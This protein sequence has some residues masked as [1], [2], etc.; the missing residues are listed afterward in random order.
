[1]VAK[2]KAKKAEQRRELDRLKDEAGEGSTETILPAYAATVARLQRLKLP[3]AVEVK[4]L[5]NAAKERDAQLFN[6]ERRPRKLHGAVERDRKIFDL[7]FS[8]RCSDVEKLEAA[9][10]P[11]VMEELHRRVCGKAI[12]ALNGIA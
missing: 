4:K 10:V 7:E 11:T 6:A 9:H 1:M 8:I 3:A 5:E 2:A 12:A